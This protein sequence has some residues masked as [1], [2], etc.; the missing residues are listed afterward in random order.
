MIPKKIHYI[1]V[2]GK[3]KPKEVKRCI[4][5]WKQKFKDFEIIEWNESNF[6]IN[7]NLYTK[8]AYEAK[9][10]AFASDYIRLYALYTMGGIYLDTDVIAVDNIDDMLD[11]KA[12]IGFENEKFVSAA[13]MGAEK[14]HPFIKQLIEHYDKI[15]NKKEFCFDDNNSLLV[16]DILKNYYGLELNNKEQTLDDGIK[17]Y[18]DKIL[19]NPSGKSKTIHIFTGTWLDEKPSLKKKICQFLK[20]R[21][22]TKK[23]AKIYARIFKK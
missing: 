19:S 8:S 16:T 17:V 13:I 22:T 10:W 4:N 18:N 21:L 20:Y 5:T 1:W 15:D 12:F 3:E 23:R 2:G 14:E 11:N 7:S 9:K 6:N